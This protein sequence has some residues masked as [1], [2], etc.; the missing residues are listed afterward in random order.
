MRNRW[1]KEVEETARPE[2]ADQ[3]AGWGSRG[4]PLFFVSM[5]NKEKYGE[6]KK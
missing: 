4:G 5:R 2:A 3:R 1:G 6:V